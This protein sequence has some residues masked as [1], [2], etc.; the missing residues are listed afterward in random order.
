MCVALRSSRDLAAAI[1]SR[2]HAAGISQARLASQA[3]VSRKLVVDLEQ[4]HP[5]A[6]ID[7]ALRVLG[8][9]QAVPVIAEEDPLWR[10]LAAAKRDSGRADDQAL[11]AGVPPEQ[12]SAASEAFG[13]ALA[14]GGRIPFQALLEDRLDVEVELDL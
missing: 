6:E 10:Q 5:R 13:R 7:S 14:S 2:R 11:A 1:R 4:G 12:V 9:L 8:A 3:G